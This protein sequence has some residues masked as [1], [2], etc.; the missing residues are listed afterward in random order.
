MMSEFVD[1]LTEDMTGKYLVTT[2]GSTHLWNIDEKY[3]VRNPGPESKSFNI[4]GYFNNREIYWIKVG[5]WPKVGSMFHTILHGDVPWHQ[6][7]TI[8]SIEKVHD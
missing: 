6:S 7:S 4:P 1:E 8:R 2:Q 3:Y 5:V